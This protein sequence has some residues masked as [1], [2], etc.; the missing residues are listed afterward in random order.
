MKAAGLLGVG[1]DS[2]SKQKLYSAVVHMSQ[3]LVP[4]NEL[5]LSI[6]KVRV[7]HRSC[8]KRG[9]V[10]AGLFRGAVGVCVCGRKIGCG[11]RERLDSMDGIGAAQVHPFFQDG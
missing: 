11:I 6:G 10:A 3:L 4:A 1:K 9:R 7:G 2:G 8:C 5:T